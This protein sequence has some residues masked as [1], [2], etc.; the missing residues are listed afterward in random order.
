M[1]VM[2]TGAT[3][4][5][6]QHI[7]F[8]LMAFYKKDLQL[9]LVGRGKK[10][11]SFRQRVET[12]L[13]ASPNK[14]VHAIEDVKDFIHNHIDFV[15]VDFS[16]KD[17]STI[18][19]SMPV[20]LLLHCASY[21]DFRSNE[22][23]QQ[24]LEQINVVGTQKFLDSLQEV[25]IGRAMYV[26]SAYVAG[27]TKGEIYPDKV[28]WGAFRNAYEAS[29]ASAEKIFQSW[30][31]ERQILNWTI[32]RPSTICGRS[33]Y[34]PYGYTTKFDVFY[35]WAQFFSKVQ[36][37]GCIR[38]QFNKQSG[39]NIIPVDVA[40][41]VIIR[42]VRNDIQNINFLHVVANNEYPHLAYTAELLKTVGFTN[43]MF[44]GLN[45][46]DDLNQLERLYYKRSVGSVFTP[47]VI[48]SAMHFVQD[49]KFMSD[50]TMDED[51][52]QRVISYFKSIL[53]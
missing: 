5:L 14:H 46:L 4:L 41:Q 34:K 37:K 53:T 23:A 33:I 9:I 43:Y 26:S 38:I 10:D 47:Y 1:K 6:G 48:N 15:D 22:S 12:I 13:Q 24:K 17:H 52:F 45:S 40:S 42:L 25:E 29:K 51:N 49:P 36:S 8:E 31:H 20:D 7:M 50:F 35:G 44:S 18:I 2:L 16:Q 11:I 30:V 32:L 3:G 27:I 39:L 21:L 19:S 28:G